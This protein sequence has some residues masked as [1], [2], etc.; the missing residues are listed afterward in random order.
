[1]DQETQAPTLQDR[2]EIV[3]IVK[4]TINALDETKGVVDEFANKQ[5]EQ[6]VRALSDSKGRVGGEDGAATRLGVN[7][8]TLLSRMKKLG[9]HP[10]QFC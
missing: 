4:E 10:K 5:R 9:I 1:M 8:T 2:D 3:R 7:R 6:I